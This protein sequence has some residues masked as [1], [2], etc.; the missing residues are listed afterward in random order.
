MDPFIRQK[1]IL[2]KQLRICLFLILIK[3]FYI[4]TQREAKTNDNIT[5]YLLKYTS[6]MF[7][8][9]VYLTLNIRSREIIQ[10][11]E[12]ISNEEFYF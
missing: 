10:V 1:C 8:F 4:S 11:I 5:K 6:I 2:G 9:L 7:E 12:N 3:I